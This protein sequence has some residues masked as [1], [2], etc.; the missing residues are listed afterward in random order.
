MDEVSNSFEVPDTFTAENVVVYTRNVLSDG[1]GWDE[2]SKQF[3]NKISLG[4]NYNLDA[5]PPEDIAAQLEDESTVGVYLKEG[6]LAIIGF[7][8]SKKDSEYPT[9]S[10]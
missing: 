2:D 3:L 4:D 7:N 8:Y 10:R 5:L 9:W 6:K 1:S